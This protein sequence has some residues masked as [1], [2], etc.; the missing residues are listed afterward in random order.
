MLVT[1]MEEE[2]RGTE[3][4]RRAAM[5]CMLQGGGAQ[6]C[7]CQTVGASQGMTW[8]WWLSRKD[9]R[10][11]KGSRVRVWVLAALALLAMA[12]GSCGQELTGGF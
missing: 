5:H 6:P 2:E 12:M 9:G 8:S 1:T 11:G 7:V 3:S 10:A 4:G